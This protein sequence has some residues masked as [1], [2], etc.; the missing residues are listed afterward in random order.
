M[1]D[2]AF[3]RL[4]IGSAYW[5]RLKKSSNTRLRC[6]K[7]DEKRLSQSETAELKM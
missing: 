6:L 1:R 3:K 7:M 2:P 4:L 5:D